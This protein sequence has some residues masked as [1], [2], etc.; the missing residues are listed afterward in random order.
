MPATQPTTLPIFDELTIGD[1]LEVA[2]EAR[3]QHLERDLLAAT[4]RAL[5]GWLS[6]Q[7]RLLLEAEAV[8]PAV[9]AL[10]SAG[11]PGSRLTRRERQVA[12]CVARGLTNRQIADELV[13]TTS[14]S[15]RHVANILNKLG[16][17][18][19]AQI[20]AWAAGQGLA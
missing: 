13:I 5:A 12:L 15:E 7:S 8:V 19:R 1:L 14:T 4:L 11:K 2:L 9:R 16:M 10:P 18:S 17:R 3:G 6:E 20:A